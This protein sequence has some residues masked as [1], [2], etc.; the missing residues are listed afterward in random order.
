MSLG[1]VKGGDEAAGNSVE[2]QGQAQ[3]VPARAPPGPPHL[4]SPGSK[5]ILDEALDQRQCIPAATF[6]TGDLGLANL[7]GS[8][9]CSRI[10]GGPSIAN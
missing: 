10:K 8:T 7:S 9:V 5:M 4:V 2:C 6:A 3:G 1:R